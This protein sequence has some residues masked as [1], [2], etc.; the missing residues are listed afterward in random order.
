[1][2]R[3]ELVKELSALKV[4]FWLQPRSIEVH[5]EQYCQYWGVKGISK[6]LLF[7][8]HRPTLTLS[9]FYHLWQLN[10]FILKV[11]RTHELNSYICQWD[12]KEFFHGKKIQIWM[13]FDN[14]FFFFKMCYIP[15]DKATQIYHFTY[16]QRLF[17]N[18]WC[19]RKK[20]DFKGG[21]LF[22]G[23]NIVFPFYL[24]FTTDYNCWARIQFRFTKYPFMG[25]RHVFGKNAQKL[26]KNTWLTSF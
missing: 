17:I 4:G 16:L 24:T 22:I 25:H 18:S 9:T 3:L 2:I 8:T 12:L 5:A 7:H 19:H 26:Q 10:I 14:S 21:M 13:F 20:V 1:M 23:Q 6:N 15:L 11:G